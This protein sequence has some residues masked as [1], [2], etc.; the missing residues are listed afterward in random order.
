M[1]LYAGIG[2]SV[3]TTSKFKHYNTL[4]NIILCRGDRKIP[5]SEVVTDEVYYNLWG[6][7]GC[8]SYGLKDEYTL[9]SFDKVLVKPG[10]EFPAYAY[11]A[12]ESAQQ[13]TAYTTTKEKTITVTQAKYKVTYYDKDQNILY[14]DVLAFGSE[15]KLRDIPKK[16][17]YEGKWE[18]LKY[19]TMPAQDISY[20]LTY[21]KAS[22]KNLEKEP[23]DTEEAGE[24]EQ[25]PVTGDW[26]GVSML[27]ILLL[28]SALVIVMNLKK[29]DIIGGRNERQ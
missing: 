16:K 28:S 18:G 17:G 5:L 6:K 11:T 10:C 9:N 2:N 1:Y 25:S 3:F 26:N 7:E 14:E 22:G 21:E 27:I 20:Q 8:I 24:T 15:L 19:E 13:M 29:R 23:D 12:N 4:E